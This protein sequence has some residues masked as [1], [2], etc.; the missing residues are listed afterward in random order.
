MNLKLHICR[1]NEGLV[2]DI[3]KERSDYV[4]ENNNFNS[5]EDVESF[6]MNYNLLPM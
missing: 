2:K 5:G 1:Y 6:R 4:E 3:Q